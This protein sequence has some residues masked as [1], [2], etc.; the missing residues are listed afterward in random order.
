METQSIVKNSKTK[1][2][3]IVSLGSAIAS[4]LSIFLYYLAIAPGFM[5]IVSFT[6]LFPFAYGLF[7]VINKSVNSVNKGGFIVGSFVLAFTILGLIFLIIA[8]NVI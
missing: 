6:S 2:I 1:V 5:L 8:I 3:D 4:A 7:G